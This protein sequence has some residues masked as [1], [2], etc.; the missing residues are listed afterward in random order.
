VRVGHEDLVLA[1]NQPVVE[2]ELGLVQ[3]EGRHIQVRLRIALHIEQNV[4]DVAHYAADAVGC[5]LEDRRADVELI[6]VEKLRALLRRDVV[7]LVD[8]LEADADALEAS[9]ELEQEFDDLKKLRKRI[10]R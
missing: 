9:V 8:D 7:P 10:H 2:E 6:G 5:R 4:F 3:L 1:V